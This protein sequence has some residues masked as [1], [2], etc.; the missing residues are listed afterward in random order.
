MKTLQEFI[1]N[2]KIFLENTIKGKKLS[3]ACVGYAL[4][5]FSLYF[6]IKLACQNRASIPGFIFAFSFWFITNVILNF[7][8]A[9]ICNT[10]LE[11]TEN[12]SSS[13]GIFIFLGL[14][15][16]IWAL[17]IP[18][19]LIANAF[20]LITP[21]IPIIA[22]AIIAGQMYFVLNSIKQIYKIPRSASMLA[23]VGAFI[24]PAV[25]GFFFFCFIIGF[26]VALTV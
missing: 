4:G 3:Y 2:P 20:P 13:L 1:Q 21:F 24:L 26:I 17:I 7:V 5:I 8:L 11:M 22:L 9:A 18:F 6:A 19:L 23:F 14:S 15:Q 10:L 12:Q 16:I 25:A